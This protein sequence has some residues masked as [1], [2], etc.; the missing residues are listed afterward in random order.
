MALLLSSSTWGQDAQPAATG[1][2]TPMA[3]EKNVP[4]Q[5][6]RPT[7]WLQD[8]ACFSPFPNDNRDPNGISVG[9]GWW[10]VSRRGSPWVIGQWQDTRSSPFWDID[11]LWT[12]GNRTLNYTATGTDNESTRATVQ[13]FG[14][15]DQGFVDL[16]RFPH[17]QEHDPFNNMRASALIPAKAG[18]PVIAQDLNKGENY[19]MRVDQ[20][21]AE[22]KYNLLG[23]PG[24]GSSWLKAG[25]NVW[26]QR[27]FGD[28]QSNN[29][30]HCF[31]A[32]SA[33]Q[34]K[35]CHVLSEKQAIDWNT[36]EVTPSLE[37]R[38][39]RLN[40]QYSHTLRVFSADDQP[41]IGHYPDGGANII[42]GDFPFAVVPQSFFNMDKI[43]IGFDLNDHNHLYAY[44]YW[45]RVENQDRDVERDLGGFDI[46]WTN[47]AVRGLTLTT[48]VKNY[49]QSA[50][51]P[52]TFTPDEKQG[53]S[54]GALYASI[55][56]PIGFNRYTMGEKFSWRPWAD[57][58]DSLFHRLTFTGGYEFDHLIRVHETW[59][60]PL[61]P[62]SVIATT[63]VLFQPNTDT[64]MLFVGIQTPWSEEI[65]TYLR[66]KVKFVENDLVGFRQTNGAVNSSLPDNR[67]AIEFGSEWFPSEYYGASF[68]QT[69]DL[70]SRLHGPLPIGGPNPLVV[71][72]VP[73]DI[74]NF[75]E[76]AYSTSLVT[77]YKPADKLTLTFNADYFSNWIKQNI[78]IGDDYFLPGD[79]LP[80]FSPLTSMWTYGGTAVELGCGVNYQLSHSLGLTADYEITFGKDVITNSGGF[81]GLG[82]FAAVRNV[83]QQLRFG[84]NWKPTERIV[85]YLRYQFVDYD[86]R[87]DSS[88]SGTL[89][90][91]LAGMS[92]H[93]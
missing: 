7:P 78:T 65:H 31:T 58:C 25:V 61:F 27:E 54:P 11:G 73:G 36:F 28:R 6:E 60:Q 72:T 38:Y 20:F 23:Q 2:K 87:T 44:G 83:T 39:D 46:R 22:Y 45:G 24:K 35:S 43:K 10:G 19:A 79:P 88:N 59:S 68:N 42:N 49:D 17:A 80:L 86:D 76:S 37:A 47:T 50:E 14:E 5:A 30:V 13:Y 57:N 92:A 85:T 34:Q 3:A 18:Q 51:R 71:G 21:E 66:Y 64:N 75:G 81:P 70:S 41:L 53:Q 29:T 52:L 16:N 48:Y 69:I 8:R 63:P 26:D 15:K 67:H 56:D 82:D 12:N 91:V 1:S 89:N 40:I 90:M 33:A 84:V 4:V 32:A 77:W 62:P 93:W 9:F 55:R 74:L